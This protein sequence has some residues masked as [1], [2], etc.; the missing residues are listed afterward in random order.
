MIALC[1]KK[2]LHFQCFLYVQAPQKWHF[3]DESKNILVVR[4]SYTTL[5][6]IRIF[7]L[8]LLKKTI[9]C[10]QSYNNLQWVWQAASTSGSI[11]MHY[12]IMLFGSSLQKRTIHVLI[13]PS[14]IRQGCH[15]I[16]NTGKAS[17]LVEFCWT[18]SR[19]RPWPWP[20][21]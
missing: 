21:P 14:N 7:W 5:K 12:Q 18:V 1:W 16:V 9:I 13:W 4:F 15:S 2:L 11:C 3:H 8:L 19:G 6:I 17:T 10:R 20:W